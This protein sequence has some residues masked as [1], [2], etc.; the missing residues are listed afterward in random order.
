MPCTFFTINASSKSFKQFVGECLSGLEL[1][2]EPGLPV[3]FNILASIRLCSVARN[4]SINSVIE[5]EHH[6]V[7]LLLQ[8][9]HSLAAEIFGPSIV[10]Q[11]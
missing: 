4:L 9:F 3:P 6:V 11:F 2:H 5:G 1:N 8:S 7:H 10:Q